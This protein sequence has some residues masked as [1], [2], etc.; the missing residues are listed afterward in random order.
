ML[1]KPNRGISPMSEIFINGRRIA[2]NEPA[3]V[4]AEIGHNHGGS[5][6]RC[7]QM[8]EAAVESGVDA[9][10][11]Q[12]RKNREVFTR[13]FYES[14]YNSPNAY[15]A[16]YG[17]HREALEFDFE[18]YK[19]LKVYSEALGVEFF[20]TAFDFSS[21]DFLE[22]LGVVCHK[23]SSFDLLNTPMQKYIAET[24]KPVI[25]STG[26]GTY[27]DIQRAVDTI[28]AINK[29]LVI[30]HC[31]T[32]YPTEACYIHLGVIAELKKR[33]PNNVMGFSDH[34]NGKVFGPPAYVL[35]ARVFEK[36]FTL[37]R[38]WKGTDQMFSLE[39]HDMAKYIRDIHNI[40]LAL[41]SEKVV[42]ECEVAPLYKMGK[43]LV[44]SR[45]LKEGEVLQISDFRIISP[46]DG[47][48]PYE[49]YRMIGKK[50]LM[51]IAEEENITWEKIG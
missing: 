45:E 18:Q 24:G 29:Q 22:K 23:I 30:L 27:E 11:L 21:V 48:P 44:A 19:E 38:R 26:G 42:D 7:K 4:C 34:F 6:E 15:A 13:A 25:L 28:T 14:P 9:V 2:D 47:V 16:T 35:G 8:I 1:F 33:Y 12:K 49:I 39:P 31:T 41:D 50:V 20:A 10:K 3:W 46:S 17:A 51:G 36:H 37:N 32:A 40:Q 43:K 5:V